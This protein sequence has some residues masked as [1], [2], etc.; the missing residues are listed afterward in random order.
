MV[1]GCPTRRGLSPFV[2]TQVA[3]VKWS[4]AGSSG[5]ETGGDIVIDAA[6][7]I[8]ASM[9]SNVLVLRPDGT[10]ETTLPSIPFG[11]PAVGVDGTL[12][13][14]QWGTGIDAIDPS[15]GMVTWS[16]GA[17]AE[18]GVGVLIRG[19][20]TIVS[21]AGDAVFAT[22]PAGVV[23][24]TA[25]VNGSFGLDCNP[26]VA[27]SGL[28]YEVGLSF[29]ALNPD[30]TMAWTRT[31]QGYGGPT[32]A[33]APD[34][35]QPDGTLLWDVTLEDPPKQPQLAAISIAPDGS[36]F[37]TGTVVGGSTLY[38]LAAADGSVAWRFPVPEMIAGKPVIDAHGNVFVAL[39]GF[40]Y[41]FHPDMTQLWVFS[42]VDSSGCAGLA[43]GSDGTV[44]T[45]CSGTVYALG[46]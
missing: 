37:A 42:P 43:I 1:G 44:Y 31:L 35:F 25:A 22:T 13:V 23:S 38:H 3:N 34:K 16:A 12:Y 46:P 33:I 40:V 20:R 29:F 19:D 36:L 45:S 5:S 11:A 41:A 39:G 27:P 18:Q 10:L 24:W 17:Q 32:P 9:L 6:G 30:G 15:T 14:P 4:Y 2:G 26:A 7:D 8:Y 21:T 28:T